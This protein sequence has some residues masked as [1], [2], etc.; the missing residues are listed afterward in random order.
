[1][2]EEPIM[3]SKPPAWFLEAQADWDRWDRRLAA[4]DSFH[5]LECESTERVSLAFADSVTG[6]EIYF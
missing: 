2:L 6:I 3:R 5:D 1:M 4:L